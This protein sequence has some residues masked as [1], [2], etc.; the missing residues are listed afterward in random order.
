MEKPENHLETSSRLR[1]LLSEQ[2]VDYLD[3][4]LYNRGV[5]DDVEDREEYK[6]GGFHPVHLG[7]N[8]GKDNRYRVIHKLGNG[9]LSTIWLCHDCEKNKYVALKIII[10]DASH[11]DCS[12]LRLVHRKDLDFDQ[13]GGKHIALPLAHFWIDGPNGS[14][15]CLVL[16]VLGP[17]VP[18]I[19][20]TFPDPSRTVR[21][22]I[23]QITSALQFLHR[24]GICH[25]G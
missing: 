25:G 10:A 18:V 6:P 20:H 7:D 21:N 1:E 5:L 12:E 16:P 14:H 3:G 4:N 19:W 11:N 22:I 2:I 15:L 8:L 9:G 24:N 17:R 13:A 23:L